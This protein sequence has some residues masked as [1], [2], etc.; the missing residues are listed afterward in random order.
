MDIPIKVKCKQCGGMANSTEF[1]LDP[2][3]AKLVC[4]SCVKNRKNKVNM[5]E[6]PKMPEP[7]KPAGWD[8]E[9][10]QI[11]KAFREKAK[12]TITAQKIDEEN[13]KYKC[14]C[15]YSFKYN[16]MKKIPARCPYCSSD[17]QRFKTF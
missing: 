16:I 6:K 1:I 13:I 4:A 7:L 15:G 11:D 8:K 5:P 10:D 2:Y 12:N 9:D 3:F 17:I 14:P